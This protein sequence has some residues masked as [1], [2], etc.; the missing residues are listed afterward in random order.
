MVALIIA[1]YRSFIAGRR[2]SVTAGAITTGRGT[3]RTTGSTSTRSTP[4]STARASRSTGTARMALHE[5]LQR[6]FLI[7][8]EHSKH[9]FVGVPQYLL[10]LVTVSAG[11]A[12]L[13]A[14]SH[15][16]LDRF[17]G[18]LCNGVYLL[19]LVT[20]KLQLGREFRGYP[21]DAQVV[22]V[23][24]QLAQRLLL[25]CGENITHALVS[26]L[27]QRPHLFHH[28]LPGCR[29]G[30]VAATLLGRRGHQI[31]ARFIKVLLDLVNLALLVIRE[32]ERIVQDLRR[33]FQGADGAAHSTGTSW[34]AW[35]SPTAGT[36]GSTLPRR[37]R[38][39]GAIR[40]TL[41]Q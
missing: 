23:A 4:A 17:L 38:T 34:S 15:Q 7:I 18:L 29:V 32:L 6:R 12:T 14:L 41:C 39:T 3:T 36:T 27:L 10:N 30:R 19:H 28:L 2:G 26:F 40:R 13:S 9:R 22:Q 24:K 16:R 31:P 1:S 8:R 5:L 25:L 33:D 35:A 21:H 20:G 37:R 11:V